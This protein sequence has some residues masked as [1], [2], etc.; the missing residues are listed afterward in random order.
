M[1][2]G[3]K[4]CMILPASIL[5]Y[6]SSNT[7]TK[8]RQRIFTDFQVTEIFDFTH[9]RRDLFH[10]TADT[11]VAAIVAENTPS[12]KKPIEHTV[13]K[14]TVSSENKIHFE[15][16]YYDQHLVPWNWAI[17]CEKQFIWK[18]NLLGGGRLFHLIYRLKALPSLVEYIESQKGWLQDRGFEGKGDIDIINFDRIVSISKDYLPEIESEELI[19][20]EKPK[21]PFLYD[22][23][24]LAIDQVLGEKSLLVSFF[25]KN[26]SYS[27]KSRVY[28]NR[29]FIGISAPEQDEDELEKIFNSLIQEGSYGFL[30]YQL[31]L[32]AISSSSLVLTETDV[33]KSEILSIPYPED[34]IPLK[35]TDSERILQSDV[36]KYY[37]HLGKSI[38]RG[39]S[40]HLI[41][42][43]ATDK[44]IQDYAKILCKELNKIYKK[45][46]R[47]WQVMDTNCSDS[48]SSCLIGF[49]KK[50]DISKNQIK[51]DTNNIEIILQNESINQSAIFK[52]VVKYYQHIEGIDCIFLIKPKNLRYWLRSIALKDAD[53]IFGDLQQEG[54]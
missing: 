42:K 15:I 26:N 4:T 32:L 39:S 18:V 21:D 50:E 34:N 16:D 6:D 14:R 30:N 40:G 35:L 45:E 51:L 13:I 36:L 38:T 25:K 22:P 37:R 44:Q 23:P 1:A 53:D 54:Y 5:L 29:D 28:F 49:C 48:F 11:P 12:S 46:D 19:S 33:N 3:K 52:R 41:N 27:D 7:A 43:R 31:Y 47:L 8:Y 2:I 9:L 24:F 17:D 10:G 20:V